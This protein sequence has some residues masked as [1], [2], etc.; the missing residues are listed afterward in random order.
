M[1]TSPPTKPTLT[2]VLR[3]PGGEV[4]ILTITAPNATPTGDADGANA[5]E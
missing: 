1:T 4:E 2:L 3:H 5:K